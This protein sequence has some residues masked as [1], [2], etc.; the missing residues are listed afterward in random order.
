MSYNCQLWSGLKYEIGASPAKLKELANE[1]KKKT[2]GKVKTGLGTRDHKILSMLGVCRNINTPLRYILPYLGG[3]G[4]NSLTVEATAASLNLFLQ[5]YGTVTSLGQYLTFS[6][7]NLQLELGVAGCPFSYNYETWNGLATDS[8]VKSLWEQIHT[9][10]LSVEIDYETLKAPRENDEYIMERLVRE[11]MHGV[12]LVSVNRAQKKQEALF[13]SDIAT[14]NGRK[15]NPIYLTDW[16]GS[17]EGQLRQHRSV[18]KYGQECPTDEDWVVWAEALKRTNFNSYSFTT[19]LGK[20]VLRSPRI[21]RAFYDEDENCVEVLSDEEGLIW[22]DHVRGRNFRRGKLMSQAEPSGLPATVEVLG[23]DILKL[24][25][26]SQRQF[27]VQEEETKFFLERLKSWG[28][29]LMWD[30]LQL[31]DDEDISW[32]A[33]SLKNKSIVCVT[34]SSYMK[35]VSPDIC[36]A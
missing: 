32:V 33:E 35:D 18:F 15:I 11:G 17:L 29:E 19:R 25:C 21:W 3:M 30:G 16:T 10:G 7:E 1:V 13:L 12:E 22:C 27:Q 14:A 28:G 6:I 8:W 36:T 34:D 4:L 20:W 31:D 5:Y 9:F 23:E 26:T 2:N 24:F